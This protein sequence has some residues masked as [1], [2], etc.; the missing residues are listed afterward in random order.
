MALRS[1]WS[2]FTLPRIRVACGKVVI[3]F[4]GL[5]VLFAPNHFLFA[6]D[7]SLVPTRAIGWWPAD[8][9]P[10]DVIGTNHANLLGG[11]VATSPGIVNAS[12][13]FDGTNASVQ[14]PDSPAFHPTNLTI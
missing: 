14:V 13:L 12:F 9:Y 7:C 3:A 4:A 5:L 11:A 10:S 8:G 2:W 1:Y 6:T